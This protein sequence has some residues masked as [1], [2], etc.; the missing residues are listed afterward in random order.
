ML[1]S[2]AL[3]C[4]FWSLL[5]PLAWP[6]S[7]PLPE[8]VDISI[9]A[10]RQP[11]HLE[12]QVRVPLAVLR[13]AQ[14]PTRPGSDSLDL[15]ALEP[16]LPGLVKYWLSPVFQVLDDGQ[17]VRPE[18][19]QAH[20]MP[21]DEALEIAFD[22]PLRSGQPV[23]AIN[24]KVAQLGLRVSTKQERLGLDFSLHGDALGE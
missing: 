13:N 12:M 4:G 18:I 19:L 1:S 3:A 17:P 9:Y 16:L 24:P 8:D 5:I 6:A 14:L 23:V 22:Y 15:D 20:I 21:P 2:R 7:R 10:N 11:G